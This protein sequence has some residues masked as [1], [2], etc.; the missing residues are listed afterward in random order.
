[1]AG[2]CERALF[3]RWRAGL[4]AAGAPGADQD[5]MER[6][7]RVTA[8]WCLASPVI[9]SRCMDLDDSRQRP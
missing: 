6:Q 3:D 4:E 5:L 1:M 8:L 9:A 7:Y 2:V